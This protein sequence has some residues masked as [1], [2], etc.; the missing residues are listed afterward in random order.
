VVRF[1]EN[2]A[3][4]R[5]LFVGNSYLYYGDSVHNHVRRI[6]EQLGPQGMGA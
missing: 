5:V 2:A 1:L 4:K 6:A 3:P